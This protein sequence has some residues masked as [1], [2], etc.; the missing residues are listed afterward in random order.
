MARICDTPIR[1]VFLAPWPALLLF[2]IGCASTGS[3]TPANSRPFDFQ[4]DTFA[5]RNDLVWEYHVDPRS[6]KT[7]TSRREPKPDYTH[8]C[9]VVARSVRQFFQHARFDPS[10]PPVDDQTY[11]RLIDQVVARSPRTDRPD[12]SRVVIPGFADLRAFST[13]KVNLLK[14]E[15]GSAVQS[16]LQRGH[17]R[18]LLPFSRSQQ[19]SMGKRLTDEVRAN[20]PPV[21]H[22]VRFPRLS[23]NHA[24]VIFDAAEDAREIRFAAYDPNEPARA[25]TL[26]FDRSRRTFSFPANDYFA[27]GRVDVYEVYR[28]GIY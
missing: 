27:G 22:V 6:G 1:W 9:F 5:F 3:L 4:R 13:A 7:V 8:H 28:R 15:C 23:I 14:A 24:L 17:W 16:Y 19:E 18:M 25:L 11:R 21:V 10:Q 20:R 2:T 26:T 12:A